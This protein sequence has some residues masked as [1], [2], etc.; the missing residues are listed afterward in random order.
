[1][2]KLVP[3]ILVLIVISSCISTK[4]IEVILNGSGS[5]GDIVKYRWKQIKGK[6]VKVMD[7]GKIITQTFIKDGV[8]YFELTVW[9]DIGQWDKDTLK[10]NNGRITN[11]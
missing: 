2:R 6:K 3:L 8:Y 11:Y 4:N 10:I 7:N 5:S 1:M 9:N